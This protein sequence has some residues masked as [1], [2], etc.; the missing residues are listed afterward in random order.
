MIDYQLVQNVWVWIRRGFARPFFD[1]PVSFSL[2][3][4]DFLGNFPD[5]IS[6]TC[7]FSKCRPRLLGSVSISF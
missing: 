3:V 1:M 6:E 2:S 4:T 5:Y 7:K